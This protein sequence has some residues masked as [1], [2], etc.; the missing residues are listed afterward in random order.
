MPVVVSTSAVTTLVARLLPL[1]GV[2][3]RD[4]RLEKAAEEDALALPRLTLP[5]LL[6]PPF[7]D[8]DAGGAGDLLPRRL[9]DRE[10]V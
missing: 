4:A 3:L 6:R 10:V 8:A 5:P 9:R 7:L 1:P 2:R